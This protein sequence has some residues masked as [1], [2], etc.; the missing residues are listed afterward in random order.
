MTYRFIIHA[1]LIINNSTGDLRIESDRVELLNNASDEFYLNA[2]NGGAVNLYHNGNKKFETTSSGAIVT[3]IAT[4]TSDVS[5]A[6]KIVHTG[7]TNTAIR[8][9]GNDTFTVETSGSEALRVDGGQRLLIGAVS[10]RGTHGGGDAQLQIEGSNTNAGMSITRTS[11]DAGSP[12]FSFGKTR[13]GSALSDG[14]DVGVIYWQ[15][16]DGTDLRIFSCSI[17]GEVDGSVSGNAVPGRITFNTGD[18]TSTNLTER[19][20]ITSGG[21]VGIGSQTPARK[22]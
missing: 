22:F 14:D 4:V 1:G 8:F 9:P 11:A 20:R 21:D 17:K 13:N 15:G 16:D 12:T 3:G 10:T 6:D 18:T 19:L 7:D 2:D 5:I